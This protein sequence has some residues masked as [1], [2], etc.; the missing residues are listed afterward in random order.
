[1]KNLILILVIQCTVIQTNI[2]QINVPFQHTDL[3]YKDYIDLVKTHNLRYVAEKLNVDI[4][5][6]SIEAAKVFQ[7]PYLSFDFIEDREG[8][9]RIDRVYSSELVK[10]IDLGGERKARIDLTRSEK[11]LTSALLA[12]YFRN[13]QAEATLVYL[14]GMKQEQLFIVRSDSYE[15]MRKLYEADSIRLSLG[16]IMQIDAIQSKLEAGILF[17]DLL[18][19]AAEW[20]NS[21]SQI[22]AMTGLIKKDTLCLPSSHFHDGSRKFILDSLIIVALNNRSDIRA[23]MFNKEVARKALRLTKKER[24]TDL[25]LKLGYADFNMTD[26]ES[27]NA[28]ALTAG[29][30]IPLKFSNFNKGELKIAEIKVQQAGEQYKQAE[31][32]IKTEIVR[33]WEMYQSYSKQLNN[34]NNGLLEN[35]ENVRKGK[36]YSYQR[37]V[38]SL[39]EVLNAQRTYNDIRTTYYET[40]FNQAASLVELEKTAGIWDISF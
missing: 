2:A 34:F 37:G 39:L 23:A 4:S 31:L 8:N 22:S 32:E 36:I 38:T 9:S 18:Q 20:K 30:A 19:S 15:T 26:P 13:L 7:D 35:A 17:N 25:D 28:S 29:I 12:D 11:E 5:E 27:P 10:T 3:A 21:L 33:A 6:A 1:M 40:V 16:S 24:R 14:E